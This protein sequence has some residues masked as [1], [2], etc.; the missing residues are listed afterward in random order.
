[1]MMPIRPSQQP[2]GGALHP[3]LGDRVHPGGGLVEDHHVRVADQDPGERDQ[4]LLPGRQHVAAL[5]ELGVD[6]RRAG[7]PTQ[8]V[9][10]SSSS[11]PAGPV[12]AGPGRTARCSRPAC[13]PGSRCAAGRSAIHR[14]SPSTSRSCRSV[15]PRKTVPRRHVDRPGQHLGQRGLARAGAADQR[16]RA[17]AGEGQVDVAQG[18]RPAAVGL[19]VA[20]GQVAHDRGRRRPA[21]RRRSA[22]AA[23]SCSSC[24]RPQAPSAFC[25][26]GTIRLT[27][28]TVPPKPSASSHTAVSRAPSM[29]PV[30]S[31]HA[32]PTTRR[33]RSPTA[34]RRRPRSR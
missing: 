19:A 31:A 22:P 27:C 32:P 11:A 7:R 17:A 13:R 9:R 2:V 16:V 3:R 29:W 5:A 34:D 6:A 33:P 20:E 18:R 8:A 25:S 26:S 14:R 10:P 21:R 23:T 24:T 12:A 4:L 15:P 1:M 28:S 30:A